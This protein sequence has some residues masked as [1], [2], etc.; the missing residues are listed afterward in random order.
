MRVLLLSM[1][2]V[3]MVACSSI[4]KV[5]SDLNKVDGNIQHVVLL[6]LSSPSDAAVNTII[7]NTYALKNIPQVQSLHVGPAIKNPRPVVDSSYHVGITLTFKTQEDLQSYVE[8]PIHQHFV[9]T[10]V[11]GKLAKM[12]VY[13]F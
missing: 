9:D 12:V 7:K 1:I 2:C 5:D 3:S 13:D 8:H 4:S 10:Y 11:K 6:W